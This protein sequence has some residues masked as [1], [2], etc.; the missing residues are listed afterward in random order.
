MNSQTAQG[1]S[2]DLKE[3]GT[4]ALSDLTL[5]IPRDV[6]HVVL[7]SLDEQPLA[8]SRRMLLQAMTEEKATGFRSQD[9]GNRRHRIDAIGESPWLVRKLAGEVR[10]NRPDAAKLKVT[11]LDQFGAPTAGTSTAE[12]ITL[13]PDVLYYL[14]EAP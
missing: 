4:I 6:A 5:S 12:Q 3:A 13:K 10:L 8:T 9:M 1:A 7:V 2:G 11:A 14:I